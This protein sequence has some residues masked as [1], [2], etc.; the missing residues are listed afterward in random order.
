M[1]ARGVLFKLLHSDKWE[2]SAAPGQGNQQRARF[3]CNGATSRRRRHDGHCRAGGRL[4]SHAHPQA[5]ASRMSEY[6]SRCQR[7]RAWLAAAN[8][9]RKEIKRTLLWMDSLWLNC[10]A[11]LIRKS[12]L[13]RTN[14]SAPKTIAKSPIRVKWN[15]WHLP[16]PDPPSRLALRRPKAR[17]ELATP[18]PPVWYADP[19][20][21]THYAALSNGSSC[22]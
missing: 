3:K 6:L 8:E 17:F 12:L 10:A 21:T 16:P 5:P 13:R 4:G 15:L 20:A 19:A 14:R 11:R 1:A 18:G 9:R 22:L 2:A 7:A